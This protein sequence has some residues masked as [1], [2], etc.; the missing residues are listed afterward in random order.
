MLKVVQEESNP[1][2]GTTAAI[3]STR[4]KR[5]PATTLHVREA[6]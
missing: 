3:E 6:R 4:T 5:F 2:K 1:S